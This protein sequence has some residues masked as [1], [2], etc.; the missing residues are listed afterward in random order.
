MCSGLLVCSSTL[1]RHQGVELKGLAHAATLVTWL[2][3]WAG[4]RG[5]TRGRL[6]PTGTGQ[7]RGTPGLP[8]EGT[9]L[10]FLL[11]GG[12]ESGLT[13]SLGCV[14]RALSWVPLPDLD[15]E[16]QASLAG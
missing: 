15:L 4:L 6:L 16:V 12:S 1:W 3:T 11:R 10:C 13:L 5:A 8:R 7:D 2:A 9:G 14:R